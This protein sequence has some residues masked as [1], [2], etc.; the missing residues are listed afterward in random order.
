MAQF[1]EIH[2]CPPATCFFL[3]FFSRSSRGDLRLLALLWLVVV[4]GFLMSA[5]RG[6]VP[7]RL[8]SAF[9]FED[10]GLTTTHEHSGR[11]CAD[12]FL[13]GRWHSGRPAWT[14]RLRASRGNWITNRFLAADQRILCWPAAVSTVPGAW[15]ANSPNVGGNPQWNHHHFLLPR[16]GSS[17]PSCRRPTRCLDA[18]LSWGAGNPADVNAANTIG[19]KWQNPK[20]VVREHRQR[21]SDRPRPNFSSNLP[22]KHLALSWGIVYDGTNVMIYQGSD[23][24]SARLIST[25]FVPGPDNFA[26]WVPP[27]PLHR[28]PQRPAAGLCG[29][30]R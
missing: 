14:A 20:P 27:S 24:A 30:D 19:M 6:P 18:C 7:R 4:A 1:H 11:V 9:S 3:R 15:A 29:L 13:N 28:Q 16:N 25:T 17:L 23:T 26:R 21:Q 12:Q 22:T 5:H 10:G 8:F 2:K